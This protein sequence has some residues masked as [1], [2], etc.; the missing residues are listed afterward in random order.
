MCS[1]SRRLSYPDAAESASRRDAPPEPRLQALQEDDGVLWVLTLVAD[2]DW[3]RA[4]AA[5]RGTHDA[6]VDDWN[7]YY[8]TVVE[9]LDADTGTLLARARVDPALLNFADDSTVTAT[10]TNELGVPFLQVWRLTL[11]FME[12][13]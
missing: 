6:Q 4:F 3:E 7:A 5:D 2:A 13:K 12:E 11:T 9:A 8:D 10:L 1:G